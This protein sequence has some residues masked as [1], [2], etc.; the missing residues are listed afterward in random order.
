MHLNF[1][2]KLSLVYC[3]I[4]AGLAWFILEEAVD[5][6]DTSVNQAAEEV[7]V[8]AAN[9]IAELVSGQVDNGKLVLEPVRRLIPAYLDRTLNANIYSVIKRHPDMHIY[10]TD[11]KGRVVFDSKG[12]EEGKDFHRWR[13]VNLTLRGFYG[14]RSSAVSDPHDDILFV[15]APVY[16]QQRIIGVVSVSKSVRGLN[17]FVQMASRQIKTYAIIA[18][19]V[20]LLFGWLMTYWLSGSIRQLVAYADAIAASG[21]VIRPQLSDHEFNRL[22]SA[23]EH[24]REE[25]EG[26]EYV[27]NYIHTLAHELKSPLTGIRGATELLQDG[28]DM[29]PE[30]R[31]QF[32][33]NI[34]NSSQRMTDLIERLLALA[35]VE[36]RQTLEQVG[37]FALAPI[38]NK[39]FEERQGLIKNKQL[40]LGH[41]VTE[42]FTVFAEQLLLEQAVSNLLDNAIDF[43]DLAGHISV[44]AEQVGDDFL[45]VVEDDGSGIPGYAHKRL[46]ERFF[47]LSRPDSG[48]RSTGLGLSFVQEVMALHH[49]QVNLENRKS[50]GVRAS[51][52]W[53]DSDRVRISSI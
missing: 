15:A 10:I 9:L 40:Q 6:F 2:F 7:M 39:L 34:Y 18:A 16:F 17:L 11:D 36:K 4:I 53:P 19:V 32:L 23:M 49:G 1:S 35:S 42:G 41:N 28:Q 20:A 44:S 43:C 48:R 33:E 47:S 26:K 51:L 29:S 45:L 27:E 31:Q 46:F 14:A 30:R 37:R 52:K 8:D 13:D 5:M 3:L 25:L 12:R 22:A 38:I 24:M 50:G 21:K